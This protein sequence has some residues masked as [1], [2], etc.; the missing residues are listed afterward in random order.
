MKHC[1][2]DMGDAIADSD[3]LT[4]Y[5]PR[6]REYGIRILD[7]G[8]SCKQIDFCPWCGRRLPASLRSK[9]FDELERRGIDPVVRESWPEEFDDERWW[10]DSEDHS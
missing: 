4:T 2:S 6:F 9:W 3:S 8:T 5:V 10:I 1:C 7:G